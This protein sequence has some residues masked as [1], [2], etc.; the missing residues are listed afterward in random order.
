MT[1]WLA[2]PPVVGLRGEI[3]VPGSKS[4]SN[5]ALVL[6]AISSSPVRIVRLLDS[7]DTRVLA[8]SLEAMGARIER[9]EG[10]GVR[11]A[12]P[13]GVSSD[14]TTLLDAGESGT[15]ARFLAALAAAVPGRFRLIGAPRLS[16]RPMAEL[17]AALRA[18]GARV[19]GESRADALP[20]GI[21]GGS[22]AS[23]ALTIDAARSSQF[24]SAL[25]IAGAALPEGIE[26]RPRGPVASAP[27]VAM[28][29][30]ALAD[31]GHGV[32][33]AED[34][35]RVRPGGN[36][37]SEYRVPGDYSST[38]PLLAACGISGG[39]ITVGGLD[40]P[41]A[42]AD[43]GALPVLE[44]MGLEIHGEMGR[45][46]ARRRDG[47]L[48]AACVRATDFPDAVPSLAALAAFAE[49]ESRF[50]G[51]AHLRDKES[52]RIA[53][54]AALLE[55]AGVPARA[56]RD[57]LSVGG[58]RRTGD[59]VLRRFPT[60]GD[61]RIAMAAALLALRIPGALI[62][63]PGCVAKSYPAFFRDL[64]SLAVRPLAS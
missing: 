16:E 33:R 26:V 52:D 37:P 41:S 30:A 25:L 14:R 61:H 53:A 17:V 38:V 51:I 18:G 7:E 1:D 56:E 57:G 43:A 15:A 11:V 24:V 64:D 48:S 59:P 39:E 44:K 45:L 29:L 6:A 28:T 46:R 55:A 12:G 54:L 10:G 47:T 62:E 19:E 2:F 40:F 21:E 60:A 42:D 32:A 5:R 4:A 8:R 3:A 31:F 20:L 49:G 34:A 22:L 27:Y 23:G 63:R 9:S 35:I 58:G 50:E 36:A 13:L